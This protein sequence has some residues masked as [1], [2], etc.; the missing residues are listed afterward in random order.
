MKFSNLKDKF[1]EVIVNETKE[2]KEANKRIEKKMN[3]LINETKI[4]KV[5]TILKDG[6]LWKVSFYYL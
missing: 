6:M 2:I 4:L 3:K 5:P 1:S